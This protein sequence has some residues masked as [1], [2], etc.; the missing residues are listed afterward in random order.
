MHTKNTVRVVQV[1]QAALGI[2]QATRFNASRCS[3][4]HLLVCLREA[5][6]RAFWT[7]SP[8]E[9]LHGR[10]KTLILVQSTSLW[11]S[12]DLYKSAL[13]GNSLGGA[14]E[15]PWCIHTLH[16]DAHVGIRQLC[17]RCLRPL[18]LSVERV[19]MLAV[20]DAKYSAIFLCTRNPSCR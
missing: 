6:T 18:I 9:E 8:G 4:L 17:S 20:T 15:H 2:L 5:W 14:R 3:S 7:C 10:R 19:E 11:Q 16:F 12:I 13:E 1:D